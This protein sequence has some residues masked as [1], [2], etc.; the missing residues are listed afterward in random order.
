MVMS[1]S[2][3][4]PRPSSGVAGFPWHQWPLAPGIGGS[5]AV[6]SVAT[7]VWHRWQLCRGI[8]GRIAMASVAA[9]AWNT[10]PLCHPSYD[11]SKNV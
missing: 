3:W 9:L 1:A 7:F 5:C 2:R 8:S 11:L 4:A 6:A 10:Q